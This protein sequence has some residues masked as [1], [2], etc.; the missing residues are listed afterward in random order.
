MIGLVVIIHDVYI[1]AFPGTGIHR[2]KLP[3]ELA[4]ELQGICKRNGKAGFL[5]LD[6]VIDVI[7]IIHRNV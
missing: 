3:K 1:P 5:K 2:V 6:S 7:R 4:G